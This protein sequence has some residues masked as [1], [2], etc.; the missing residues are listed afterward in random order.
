MIT[1]EV[2]L[3]MKAKDLLSMQTMVQTLGTQELRLWMQTVLN[4]LMTQH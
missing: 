1:Q 2:M 4:F 3:V